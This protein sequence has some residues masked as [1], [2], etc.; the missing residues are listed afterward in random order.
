MSLS[1]SSHQYLRSPRSVVSTLPKTPTRREKNSDETTDLTPSGVLR[2]SLRPRRRLELENC[3]LEDDGEHVRKEDD[4]EE[5][6]CCKQD[7]KGKQGKDE[8]DSGVLQDFTYLEKLITKHRGA[9]GETDNIILKEKEVVKLL[10]KSEVKFMC[11]SSNSTRKSNLPKRLMSSKTSVFRNRS[12]NEAHY[13]LRACTEDMV[14]AQV[15]TKK[16]FSLGVATG[17]TLGAPT[18]GGGLFVWG[19]YSREREKSRGSSSVTRREME[20]RCTVEPSQK[21]VATESVYH[22]DY[23][24]N[25]KFD[26][27]VKEGYQVTYKVPNKNNFFKAKVVKVKEIGF[28]ECDQDFETQGEKKVHILA[29]FQTTLTS[30]EHEIDFNVEPI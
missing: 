16:G 9:K 3:N 4:D 1:D 17:L 23:E 6:P 24:A 29:T 21:V 7:D 14:V 11:F 10:K 13:S 27:S 2:R 19:S 22:T 15:T 25:C 20:A 12:K 8:P 18:G 28:E 5:Q 30:V 26:F